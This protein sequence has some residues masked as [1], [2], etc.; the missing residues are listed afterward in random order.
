V[1]IVYFQRGCWPKVRITS[2]PTKFDPEIAAFR[3]SPLREA[4]PVKR[5]AAAV[6]EGAQAVATL[7][8][9][10]AATERAPAATAN[11]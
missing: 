9:Y 6:G 2:A 5:V 3:P 1:T 7:H 8:G 11:R 10:L 4:T